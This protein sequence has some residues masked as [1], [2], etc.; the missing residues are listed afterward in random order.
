[1]CSIC[2]K[3]YVGRS[4]RPLK[5][6][7]GEHRRHYYS[8]LNN[9]VCDEKKDDQALG[10]HLYE[11]G[12]REESDF[13]NIYNVSVLQIC[14][15]RELEVAEHRFIHKLNSLRPNGLNVS[16]PFEIPLLYKNI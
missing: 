14:S 13:C 2:Q 5:E 3:H 4:T 1:M 16:N 12:C 6:R 15:P 7:I 8:V 9:N 11:H 10:A